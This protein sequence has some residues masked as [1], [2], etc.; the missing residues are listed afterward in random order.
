MLLRLLTCI[1][2][3]QIVK[4][5]KYLMYFKGISGWGGCYDYVIYEK[6]N[7]L[8]IMHNGGY[9]GKY[10]FSTEDWSYML[11][12]LKDNHNIFIE[13]RPPLGRDMFRST[14]YLTSKNLSGIYYDTGLEQIL[15]NIYNTAKEVKNE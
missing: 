2:Y 1:L 4:S 8:Y 15:S 14:L 3:K 5:Q 10:Q 7:K 12:Y 6:H 11:Q 13:K 9:G